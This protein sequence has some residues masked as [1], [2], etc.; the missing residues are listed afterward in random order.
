MALTTGRKRILAAALDAC[1]FF[2]G[3]VNAEGSMHGAGEQTDKTNDVIG[4]RHRVLAL[5]T[6]L[7]AVEAWGVE[8]AFACSG[9]TLM[10]R[11]PGQ[12]DLPDRVH[13]ASSRCFILLAY[14]N[15]T[16]IRYPTGR[17]PLGTAGGLHTNRPKGT[18]IA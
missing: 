6:V 12:M 4:A 11:S 10:A 3:C 17:Q 2:V 13:V 16:R 18:E 8:E 5:T 9:S 1:I 7:H 15:R 14:K